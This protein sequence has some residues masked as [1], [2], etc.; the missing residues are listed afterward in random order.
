MDSL[1]LNDKLLKISLVHE[2]AVAHFGE[3]LLLGMGMETD[4][5]I[6]PH[7]F[8]PWITFNG[9]SISIQSRLDLRLRYI[10]KLI[11]YQSFNVLYRFPIRNGKRKQEVTF[12]ASFVR[13]FFKTYWNVK[14]ITFKQ[15]NHLKVKQQKL[16]H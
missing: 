4:A 14:K 7:T 3:E 8:I 2:C 11:F 16:N 6:P 13:T 9:V 1:N 5:L 15:D 12:N 10:F